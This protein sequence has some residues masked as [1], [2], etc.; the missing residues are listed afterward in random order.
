MKSTSRII[1][2]ARGGIINEEDLSVAL[3]N[4]IIAGAAIDVFV[5]EP[6]LKKHQFWKNPNVTVTPHIA[7]VTD[8]D[9]SIDYIF[10]KLEYFRKKR[11]IK[12]D[13]FIN[14]GY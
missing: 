3:N 4:D 2:V 13:V 6:L 9:S 10:K 1:N 14:R 5:K 11:K 7:A 8:V 12:S